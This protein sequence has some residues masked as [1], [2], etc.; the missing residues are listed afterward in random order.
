MYFGVSSHPLIF[1]II[2]IP[3]FNFVNIC[4]LIHTN[5][6]ENLKKVGLLRPLQDRITNQQIL[7][8]TTTLYTEYNI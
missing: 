4:M 5:A 7:G 6:I 8:K 1:F 2:L 3:F